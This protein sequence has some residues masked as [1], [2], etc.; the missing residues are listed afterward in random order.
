MHADFFNAWQ[1]GA[2]KD[3]VALHQRGSVHGFE[4]EAQRLPIGNGHVEE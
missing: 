4:S 1:K 2:L 3:L